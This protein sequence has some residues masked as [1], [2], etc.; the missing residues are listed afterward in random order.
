MMI[1][2]LLLLISNGYN[3]W[4][5]NLVREVVLTLLLIADISHFSLRVKRLRLLSHMNLPTSGLVTLSQWSG[6]P[7]YGWMK[8]LLH[9]YHILTVLFAWIY[10]FICCCFLFAHTLRHYLY[11]PYNHPGELF[12]YWLSVSGVENLD[13]ISWKNYGWLEAGCT[14][15]ITPYWSKQSLPDKYALLY[16]FSVPTWLQHLIHLVGWMK[17][18]S[19]SFL[20][21]QKPTPKLF[22]TSRWTYE[23]CL[24]SE[25]VCI[26]QLK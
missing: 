6:G 2:T 26:D 5:S 10:L 1:S 9:G 18:H 3:T 14:G 7:I 4:S 16:V 25:I 19:S 23:S 22:P 8:V 24:M 17:F 11:E 20:R 12:G 13:S 15:R 21:T